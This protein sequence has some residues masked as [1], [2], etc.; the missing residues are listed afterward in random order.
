M[1]P[2]AVQT[3]PSLKP[4]A[5]PAA[6]TPASGNPP[7]LAAAGAKP[8]VASGKRASAKKQLQKLA[9]LTPPAASKESAIPTPVDGQLATLPR[10]EVA[11]VPKTTEQ[12]VAPPAAATE[13]LA[14]QELVTTITAKID[15]GYGNV[16]FIRGQ[17][18][19]LSWDKGVPLHCSDPSTWVWTTPTASGKVVFKLLIN[20]QVWS[21]G[22]DI[23]VE[24]GKP[25]EVVPV[26]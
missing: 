8:A 5:S 11:D 20:D 17:G 12:P 26:F 22:D 24:A 19:G 14:P 23:T 18:D 7:A 4:A 16:L 2:K 6:Q 13:P 1:K 25:A 10:P 21:R 9:T 3:N 15:V